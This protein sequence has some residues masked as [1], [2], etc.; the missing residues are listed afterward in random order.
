MEAPLFVADTDG[1]SVIDGGFGWK[2]RYLWRIWI[3]APLLMK[4]MD[5]SSAI[6]GGYG[7]KLRC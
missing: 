5:E 6:D 2:L 1:S 7:R 4:D 3:E